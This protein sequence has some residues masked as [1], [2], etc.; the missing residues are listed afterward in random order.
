LRGDDANPGALPDLRTGQ[1]GQDANGEN[2]DQQQ[3]IP[4]FHRK[5]SFFEM[6]ET[7]TSC[8]NTR[9]ASDN[10]GFFDMD[11]LDHYRIKQKALSN[12]SKATPRKILLKRL[13]HGAQVAEDAGAHGTRVIRKPMVVETSRLDPVNHT[14]ERCTHSEL[15]RMKVQCP[16]G[17]YW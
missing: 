17:K 9:T 11:L 6:V 14:I 13:S 2:Q 8:E 16:N 1:A 5:L 10:Q 3:K 12:P 15:H 7:S 4:F